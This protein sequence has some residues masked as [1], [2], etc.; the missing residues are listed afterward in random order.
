MAKLTESD[1]NNSGLVS[2][3]APLPPALPLCR[4]AELEQEN[5]FRKA[6]DPPLRD[7]LC[8]SITYDLYFADM[9][10]YIFNI[11]IF[12]CFTYI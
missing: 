9:F 12:M 10:L 2:S 3:A 1:N 6:G 5:W 11:F 4:L 8:G 7:S